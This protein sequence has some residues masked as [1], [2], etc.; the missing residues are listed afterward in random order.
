MSEFPVSHVDQNR[1]KQGFHGCPR[2]LPESQ[3]KAEI[4]PFL[5]VM[6]PKKTLYDESMPGCSGHRSEM[7]LQEKAWLS[8]A[9]FDSGSQ[10]LCK[11]TCH[12]DTAVKPVGQLEHLVSILFTGGISVI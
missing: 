12:A 4:L 6:N 2:P 11:D 7:I 9:L 8:F 5:T 1:L 3:Y 10:F